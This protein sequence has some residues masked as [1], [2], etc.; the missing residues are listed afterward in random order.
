MSI[1]HLL[2]LPGDVSKADGESSSLF[3]FFRRSIRY[4]SGK[5]LRIAC[6]ECGVCSLGIQHAPYCHLWLVRLYS[7]FPHYLISG[8]I[9]EKVIEH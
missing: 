4:C 5:A 6:Y 8:K 9:L 3:I 2:A 7:I 1:D